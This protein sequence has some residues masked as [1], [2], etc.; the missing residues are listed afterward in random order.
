MREFVA[1]SG[2]LSFTG[3]DREEI[4]GF[5]EGTWQARQYLR[6][7]KKDKGVVRRYLATISGR[8]LAQITRL[9]RRYRQSGSVQPR[10]PRRHRFPG[11]Y[12]PDDMALLAVVDAAHEGLSGAGSVA[13]PPARVYRLR[14]PRI[15]APGVDPGLPQ[16]PSAAQ[17]G[18]ASP[19][20]AWPQDSPPRGGEWRAAAARAAQPPSNTSERRS[21]PSAGPLPAQ[22]HF[23]IIL[24]SKKAD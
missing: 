15:P 18:L 2:S 6:L 3:A 23:R 4:Y 14:P 13:H 10:K 11:R 8:S 16:L 1:A 17:R 21:T 24:R 12:S 5:V 7:S 19:S 22:P 9:I 20:R